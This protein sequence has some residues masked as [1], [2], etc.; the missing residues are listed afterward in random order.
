MKPARDV[1]EPTVGAVRRATAAKRQIS[2]VVHR[3]E[4]VE[5]TKDRLGGV[6]PTST[7]AAFLVAVVGQGIAGEADLDMGTLPVVGLTWERQISRTRLGL[8]L[9]GV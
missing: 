9:V 5:S 8:W 6:P 2:K 1:D 4:K 3:V 7:A